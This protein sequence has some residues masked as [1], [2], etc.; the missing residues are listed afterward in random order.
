MSQTLREIAA[1]RAKKQ[2]KQVDYLLNNC[3]LLETVQYTPST[4]GLQHAYEILKAVTGGGFVAIDQPL[5]TADAETELKWASLG[6]LGFTI[7]AGVDKVN[8]VTN[9]GTFADYL[10]LK[11]P[12]IMRRTSMD[13][14]TAIIY[15]LLLPFALKHAKAVSAGGK[16][17]SMFAIRWCEEEFCG[18]YDE[19][20]FGQ[21]AVLETLPLSGGSPYK[22]AKGQTVYGA[23]FK[24]YLGFLLE[25]PQCVGT[26]ANIDTAH[27]PTATMVDDMLASARAGDD[28]TTFIF[29]H[30]KALNMLSD[31]K[32][33]AIRMTTGDT[34]YSRAL[35]SWNQIPM[36][37]SYNFKDGT[38]GAVTIG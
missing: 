22:N 7:E 38:E 15:S 34:N 21:G 17:Y 6:I 13:T 2:P 31:I 36:V 16:G 18:L 19:S 33:T 24:S 26:I 23:D 30:P 28:G 5:P 25:N 11:S 14:E 32:G 35:S 8:Q 37:G 4:H 9:G 27:R 1:S 29:A 20:G 10:A 12:K 3:P